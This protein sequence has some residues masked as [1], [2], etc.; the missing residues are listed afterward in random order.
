MKLT[1]LAT[2]PRGGKTHIARSGGVWCVYIP[3]C[4]FAVML[5]SLKDVI[6]VMRENRPAGGAR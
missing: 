3:N 6:E 2:R 5:G 4:P 1:G